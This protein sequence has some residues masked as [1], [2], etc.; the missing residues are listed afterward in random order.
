MR[1]WWK[2]GGKGDGIG[3]EVTQAVVREF[4]KEL[5]GLMGSNRAFKEK[6]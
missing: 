6:K 5:E 2:L 4:K 3:P 1:A